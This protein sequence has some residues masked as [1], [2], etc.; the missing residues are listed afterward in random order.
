MLEDSLLAFASAQPATR[1]S[2]PG[3]RRPEVRPGRPIAP[4]RPTL[5][6]DLVKDQSGGRRVEQ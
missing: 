5:D 1:P 3:V 6:P 2:V 4:R